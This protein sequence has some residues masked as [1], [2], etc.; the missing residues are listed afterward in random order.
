MDAG[1]DVRERQAHAQYVTSVLALGFAAFLQ[2]GVLLVLVGSCH[3]EI[4]ASLQLSL[5][6]LS[7][8]GAVVSL[9]LGG[10]LLA[11][12]PLVD[13]F[14][15]RV[16]FQAALLTTG[17]ALVGIGEGVSF[18]RAMAHLAL[19]GVGAGIYET[20]LNAS[21]IEEYRESAARPVAFVHSA[22]TAGA[23]LAPL[24]IGRLLEVADWTTAFHVLGAAHFIVFA[25][26]FAVPFPKLNRGL[27]KDEAVASELFGTALVA[28]CLMAFAYVGIET[29]L[30]LLAVPYAAEGLGL[31]PQRGR[32]AISS[33]WLGLLI[34]RSALFLLGARANEKLLV[35]VGLVSAL[36]IGGGVAS[37]TQRLELFI[38]GVGIAL[39][40][41]FPM[42]VTLAGRRSPE[43][44]GTAIGLVAG[45]GLLGG[46]AVPWLSGA[47]GQHFG[48]AAAVG[49]LSIGCLCIT[50]GALVVHWESGSR[51]VA[52]NSASID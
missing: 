48:V 44:S 19:A 35:V 23:M 21:I 18:G 43:R 31:D 42:L 6:Q 7:V 8:L 2:F 36:V 16:I 49:G 1:H 17:L 4:S 29:A 34:G 30:T 38:G 10:G 40:C 37:S 46:F 15:R 11:G 41:V 52:S 22:A 33:F 39:G 9:G 27:P 28:L 13:R 51:G 47:A 24:S 50:L 5:S 12:G 14:P 45:I 25:W 20:G 32:A 3:A 26:A